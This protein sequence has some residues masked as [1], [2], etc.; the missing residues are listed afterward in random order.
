MFFINGELKPFFQFT[1]DT[2][3]LTEL[4]LAYTEHALLQEELAASAHNLIRKNAQKMLACKS[5]AICMKA[6]SC[7]LREICAHRVTA[8]C[9]LRALPENKTLC[10]IFQML[11][12]NTCLAPCEGTIALRIT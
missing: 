3:K 8:Q 12:A 9:L 6:K 2:N 11:A 7:L 4:R 5:Y 1:D 10:T